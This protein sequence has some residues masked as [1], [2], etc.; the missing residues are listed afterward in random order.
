MTTA[1]TVYTP[2]A[3]QQASAAL[4]LSLRDEW[5]VVRVDGERYIV[6]TSGK[7]GH[8]YHVRADGRG[9][10][11]PWSQRTGSP[12][13]HRLAIIAAAHQDAL[14]EWLADQADDL[15]AG[16]EARPRTPTSWHPCAANCGEL[17]SPEHRFPLCDH[18]SAKRRRMLE[19]D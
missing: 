2:T 9:C 1:T 18:C 13:S 4:H 17:L 11:C 8:V 7:S 14:A 19:V 5:R 10:S 12:C 15:L 16:Y 6:L 3:S